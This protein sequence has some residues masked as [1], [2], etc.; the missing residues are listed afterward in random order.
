MLYRE[1]HAWN[2]TTDEA[3]EIQDEL[4]HQ[5]VQLNRFDRIRTVAGVDIGIRKRYRNC[6]SGRPQLSP[7]Y[8]L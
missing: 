5:V 4:C 7:I 3:K 6:I 1:L 8:R 2:V